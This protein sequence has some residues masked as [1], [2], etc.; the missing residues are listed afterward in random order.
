MRVLLVVVVLLLSHAAAMAQRSTPVQLLHPSGAQGDLFGYHVA[1]DGDTVIVGCRNDDFPGSLNQGS[2]L[3]YRW[4]GSGWSLEAT[5]VASDGAAGDDFGTSV[6]LDGDMAVVGAFVADVGGTVDPRPGCAYVF[7][8]SGTTWTQHAKLTASDGAADNFFGYSVAVTSGTVLIGAPLDT[9]GSNT[10]QGSAYLFVRSG[11]AWT[12]QKLTA[13]DGGPSDFFGASVALSG[14]T[15]VIGAAGHDGGA[16]DQG[17]AYVFVRSGPAWAPQ[18]KLTPADGGPSDFFGSSVALSGDTAVIGAFR[19]DVGANANQ[20]S[21][22]VFERTAGTW[23]QQALLTATNG[24]ANDVFGNSVDIDGESVLVG[25]PGVD[26]SP[27]N[28]LGAAYVFRRTGSIW[29]QQSQLW[30]PDGAAQDSWGDRVA[31]SG[32]TAIVAA[33]DDDLFNADQGSAWVFSRMKAAPGQE[34]WVGPNMTVLGSSGAANDQFGASAAISGDYAIVGARS[35]DAGA[36]LDQGRAHIFL[37]VGTAWVQQATLTAPDGAAG[38]SFGVSVAIDAN[39]AVVGAYTGDIGV[40]GNQGAAYVFTRSGTTWNFQQKLTAADGAADDNFGISVAVSGNTVLVGAHVDDVGANTDQ[41]S[42]Y[43]FTRFGTTWSLQQKLTSSDGAAG[44]FFGASVALVGDT[45]VIG[46]FLDDVGSNLDQGSVYAFQRSGTAWSQQSKMIASDGASGDK[47][48]SSVALSGTSGR[49]AAGSAFCDIGPNADQGAVY[50]FRAPGWVQLAKL[51][52]SDGAPADHLGYSVAINGSTVLAGAYLDDVGT[53]IDQGTGYVFLLGSSE[54]WV[55]K[56]RLTAPQGASGDRLG[57][58]AA[59]SL[60]TALLGS[61]LDNVGTNA[62]QGSATF[63]STPFFLFDLAYHLFGGAIHPSLASAVLGASDG[64]EI[65]ASTSAFA[66]GGDTG[67]KSLTIFSQGPIRISRTAEFRL[68]GDSSLGSWTG[69]PI[70][71]YGAMRFA[72]PGSTPRVLGHL[73]AAPGASLT[74]DAETIELGSG[75]FDS[76]ISSNAR[77]RM[78]ACDLR[79]LG[80]FE[81]QT[82]EVMSTDIGPSPVG[83]DDSAAGHYPVGTVR[84]GPT[85]PVTFTLVDQRDND[86]LGQQNC[87]ALYVQTLEVGPGSRLINPNCRIYAFTVNNQ[88]VID[89]PENV[90]LYSLCGSA[91]FNGDGDLGTDGDIEAFFACLGG[92]CCASCGSADFNG[93]GDLGTDADI[94][95]FFRVLGGGDC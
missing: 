28:D 9:V 4:T 5:L 68:D 84:F 20:G 79:L 34:I 94:E 12:E 18:G 56:A 73:Y 42:A 19:H 69:G 66:A 47:L 82:F 33:K 65:G 2:A 52:A 29:T 46:A 39:T 61:Y 36:S 89:H 59:L 58:A 95:A 85:D 27:T 30:A 35:G 72:T 7:I 53:S 10:E 93:D 25:A 21:V 55:Q 17:C 31:L 24:A 45:A 14:D 8:R 43:V 78:A 81:P 77:F 76:A 90:I 74:A 83:L 62:D 75:N 41:G 87:E 38:D 63:F 23:S 32:D 64:A 48:G 91:D 40:N 6:A 3:V 80:H 22:Y 54:S 1:A 70:E 60:D 57:F 37:R 49:V 26:R 16:T 15:A 67:T 71:V 86:G 92:E 13:A 50:I 11:N 88:G 44:D 51:T